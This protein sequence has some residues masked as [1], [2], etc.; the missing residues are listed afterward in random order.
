MELS[1]QLSLVSLAL[2]CGPTY[3]GSFNHVSGCTK[4]S[5]PS[6]AVT[7]GQ[8]AQRRARSHGLLPNAKNHVWRASHFHSFLGASFGES[9]Y[10]SLRLPC[11]QAGPLPVC[12]TSGRPHASSP[13]SWTGPSGMLPPRR[14]GMY[15]PPLRLCITLGLASIAS[16]VE[17][18]QVL[19]I[20][21][22]RRMRT[23]VLRV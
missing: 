11:R 3:P 10:P 1:G 9:P 20:M 16:L 21:R 7:R 12:A 22:V 17:L 13:P 19:R 18:T 6:S 15:S 14:A 5:R 8:S 23:S 4:R 2:L